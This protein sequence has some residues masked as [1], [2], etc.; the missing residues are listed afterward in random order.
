VQAVTKEDVERV[1]KSYLVHAFE[2]GASNLAITTNPT[3]ADEV[4]KGFEEAGWRVRKAENC[5]DVVA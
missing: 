3:K 4:V 1:I 2:P 5:E